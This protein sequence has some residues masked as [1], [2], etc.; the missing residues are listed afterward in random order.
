MVA[1][2]G[3]EVF[4]CVSH[5]VPPQLVAVVLSRVVKV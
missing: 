1:G 3:S 5:G 2:A 4:L